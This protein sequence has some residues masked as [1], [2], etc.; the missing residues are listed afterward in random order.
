MFTTRAGVTSAATKRFG[1]TVDSFTRP[2][3][4]PAPTTTSFYKWTLRAQI[5]R[6]IAR[7][8]SRATRR[9]QL[10][11]PSRNGIIKAYRLLRLTEDP[12][13][14]RGTAT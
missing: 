13:G 4:S 7:V 3:L 6:F 8:R 10:S 12:S 9:R 11:R 14:A 2:V 1:R 5:R